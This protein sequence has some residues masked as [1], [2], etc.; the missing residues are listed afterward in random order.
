MLTG[1]INPSP[2]SHTFH[3]E[4]PKHS[5]QSLEILFLSLQLAWDC[6]TKNWNLKRPSFE[7]FSRSRTKPS[8]SKA[9]VELS[10]FQNPS[11]I[12]GERTSGQ[13]AQLSETHLQAQPSGSPPPPPVLLIPELD[14]S[15]PPQGQ[16]GVYNSLSGRPN[17]SPLEIPLRQSAG[18]SEISLL[19]QD[20]D[21]D[22]P[23]FRTET[24]RRHWKTLRITLLIGGRWK[25]RQNKSQLQDINFNFGFL[26][27]FPLIDPASSP[28]SSHL[29][30]HLLYSSGLFLNNQIQAIQLPNLWVIPI[31]L[32]IM[33]TWMRIRRLSLRNNLGIRMTA[34]EYPKLSSFQFQ[35][36]ISWASREF[37]SSS[38]P[39]RF[40]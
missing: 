33:K 35:V 9:E 1:T 20:Q 30:S 5:D 23:L 26:I 11:F 24:R 25:T 18:P 2:Y 22:E 17:G 36:R 40:L 34:A 39:S 10:V 14:N 15:F 13:S 3:T 38:F 27:R 31:R 8:K 16:S 21:F 19:R 7:M 28:P 4:P 32:E 37:R 12:P 6:G 29:V